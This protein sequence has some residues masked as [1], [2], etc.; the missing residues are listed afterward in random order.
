MTD[1]QT[2]TVDILLKLKTEELN[3]CRSVSSKIIKWLG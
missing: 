2:H 3:K 1:T